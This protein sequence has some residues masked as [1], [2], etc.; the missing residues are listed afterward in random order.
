MRH[1]VSCRM[2]A[3]RQ[4]ENNGL[5][6]KMKN[7]IHEIEIAL[8]SAIKSLLTG[9]V[10]TAFLPVGKLELY[11]SLHVLYLIK[12]CMPQDMYKIEFVHTGE[13]LRL[14]CQSG[15]S[16]FERYTNDAVERAEGALTKHERS[17]L[18]F[19]VSRLCF[20]T[21]YAAATEYLCDEVRES[22]R[23]ARV[24]PAREVHARL[25]HPS[26]PHRIKAAET[27]VVMEKMEALGLIEAY[28]IDESHITRPR[29]LK[30]KLS[31]AKA[32]RITAMCFDMLDVAIQD[33][34]YTSHRNASELKFVGKEALN[35][36]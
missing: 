2:T 29:L 26:Y 1:I 31:P 16:I 24:I 35:D 22:Y 28:A 20:P 23:C 10:Q 6:I 3:L 18:K 19:L 4:P 15:G 8:N 17:T 30:S 33:V 14:M 9:E 5:G 25:I 32:F 11:E 7:R 36:I 27:Q 34:Y 13:G 21:L 12:K